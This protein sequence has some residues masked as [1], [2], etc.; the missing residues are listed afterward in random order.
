VTQEHVSGKHRLRDLRLHA[1]APRPRLDRRQEH[2]EPLA[3][4]LIVD[5]PFTV[6]MGPEHEPLSA[7]EN[8]GFAPFGSAPR[9]SGG[10][11]GMLSVD[12][13]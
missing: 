8:Q 5:E 1:F 9:L 13:R 3:G 10:G 11:T 6:A 2:L 7:F 12:T 4:E